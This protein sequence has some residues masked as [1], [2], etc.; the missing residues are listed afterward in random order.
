[1]PLGSVAELTAGLPFVVLAP[2]PDDETLGAGGLI[3][4]ACEAGQSAEV[5]IIT[6][7]SGSHPRSK[8]YP[9]QRL[10][11][12]RRRE[13]ERAGALLGLPPGRIRHLGLPDTR[14]PK[15]GPALEAALKAILAIVRQVGAGA[16]FTTWPGD[17][18]S[19]HEAAALMAV[20]VARCLPAI[21]LWAYPV[22][23][24]HLD[25]R[26]PVERPR[27]RGFRIDISRHQAK[28]RAALA[29]H[30]SQMTDLVSDDPEGFRFSAAQLE[31]FLGSFEYFIEMA[32]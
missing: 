21:R 30:L 18:H 9:R 20:A 26:L 28:K 5:V 24:W 17:P 6:D 1:M 25:P 16:L 29:A 32:P 7:G 2:H 22:W 14:A 13:V 12:L 3:A 8:L 15:D 31:P 19:D 10:I 4:A 23:A 27:P 11:E